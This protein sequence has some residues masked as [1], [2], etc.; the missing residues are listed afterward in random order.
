MEAF[1]APAL[2]APALLPPSYAAAPTLTVLRIAS[3]AYITAPA[4]DPA[5]TL[6]TPR[7]YGDITVGQSGAD[8][9]GI[10]GRVALGLAEFEVQ[11]ADRGLDG[12]IH[13][14]IA[15]GRPVTVRAL[16]VSAPRAGHFGAAL[17][18]VPPAFVGVV[19]RV[20]PA[21]G[22]R[23]RFA[24]T[25]VSERLAT[26]LQGEKF[27]GTGGLDG[28]ANLAGKPKPVC[29]GN[30][31]NL[32]PVYIGNVDLGDGTLPTYAIHGRPISA[33]SAVRIR[34]VEQALVGSAPSVGEYTAHL[35]DGVIQLGSQADGA[36]TVDATGDSAYGATTAAVIRALV[37][38]HGPQ[39]TAAQIDTDSFT[40]ADTDLPGA[41][42]YYRADQEMTAAAA[43][44]EVLAGCGAI[45]CGG[46]GGTLRLVDPLAAGVQQFGIPAGWVLELEPVSL[47]AALRPLPA[48]VAV[49]YRRNWTPL[50]D[51]AGSI[52]DEDD[53]AF[54]A[55]QANIH[56]VTSST[57]AFRVQ[58]A[59]ELR[60]PGLYASEA[61]AQARAER[62]QAFLE[63]GPRMFRLTTDR[64][65]GQIE[66]GDL[67]IIQY[68]AYGLADGAGVVVLGYEDR[69]AARRLVLTVCTVPWVTAA[70]VEE[71]APFFIL[72]ETELA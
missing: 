10:G 2:Y 54:L 12:L 43:V 28:G 41:V 49:Q 18:S 56:R 8:A 64:Y 27:G 35:A 52:S 25:D 48:T 37:Q 13:Y 39:L 29:V 65:L 5:S 23:A 68:P 38:A 50:S 22:Q 55:G 51:I 1:S 20:D 61:D 14:G 36:V 34:G 21:A 70:P 32:A 15:D 62:W 45:L 42:G 11:N 44:D 57:I 63:A 33:V 26:P 58:Q 67:G 17:G 4:D 3:A 69:L 9:L 6:Y 16:P 46:R 47:P 40:L 31:A 71:E 59:R 19:Q 60:F 66:V 72:D 30:V 53:R 7:L 24:V